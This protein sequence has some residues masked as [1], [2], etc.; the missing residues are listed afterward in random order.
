MENKLIYA[1]VEAILLEVENVTKIKLLF[2][3]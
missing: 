1:I 2:K 3:R